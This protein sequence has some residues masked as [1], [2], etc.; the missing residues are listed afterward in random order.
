MAFN[1]ASEASKPFISVSFRLL[2][3]VDCLDDMDHTLDFWKRIF[4]KIPLFFYSD[5]SK[6]TCKSE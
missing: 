5:V 4:Q 2:E 6:T 3:N 1:S